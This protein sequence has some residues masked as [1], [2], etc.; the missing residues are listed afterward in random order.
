M[1]I[2]IAVAKIG[3][4]ATSESG[5]TLEMIERPHGG[6]SFVLVDGQRSG[7]GAKA[8]SNMVARK[9]ISLL[10][11]G[12]RDGAA[13]RAAHDYLYAQRGGKVLATLN[14]LSI[15]MATKTLV[16]SRNSHCPTIVQL[17]PTE[18]VILDTPSDPVGV[19]RV[20]RPHIEEF[21]LQNGMVAIVFT[22]GILSAGE[23]RGQKLDLPTYVTR[24][25]QR[26]IGW[27]TVAQSI[28]DDLLND[29]LELDQGR[30]ADDMSV[31]VVAV[32]GRE[33]DEVRR[34]QVTL[35]IPPKDRPT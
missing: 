20:T 14:I 7:K 21:P 35:P 23:R 30:P 6:L 1:Q 33:T 27:E 28:A 24:C 18:Q 17:S 26:N 5:D 15:D 34:M 10:G 25:Y 16:I 32:L 19:R 4:Y 22:D 8:I 12:V 29:A 9:A 3:K 31:L 2:Q 13:A 11:E